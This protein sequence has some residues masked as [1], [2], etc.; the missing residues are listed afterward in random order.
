MES[1]ILEKIK[2]QDAKLDAIYRSVEK[3]RKYLFWKMVF[4]ILLFIL[5]LIGLAFV[6]PWL[7][8]TL[9]ATYGGLGI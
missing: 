6:I 4:S 1:E 7:L 9:K 8:E 2:E 5:P 3:T